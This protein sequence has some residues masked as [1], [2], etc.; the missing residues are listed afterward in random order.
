[1]KLRPYT[2]AARITTLAVVTIALYCDACSRPP[3]YIR[4]AGGNETW[5][6]GEV[7]PCVNMRGAFSAGVPEEPLLTCGT[8]EEIKN[9]IDLKA[10]GLLRP[11]G[12]EQIAL[13]HKE[14]VLAVTATNSEKD[15]WS[16]L[17]TTNGLSCTGED[18][19][20]QAANGPTLEERRL[21]T[22]ARNLPD[23][24]DPS[25]KNLNKLCKDTVKSELEIAAYN[26]THP[27]NNQQAQVTDLRKEL[28]GG[29]DGPGEKPSANKAGASR[30]KAQFFRLC[31][32]GTLPP[33]TAFGKIV[34]SLLA[35]RGGR[36]FP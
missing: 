36:R 32:S 9:I 11:I 13:L 19:P 8:E 33:R 28:C 22:W 7:R 30:I 24:V 1:M 20:R 16:C 10:T 34:S 18:Q 6:Q 21:A 35:R 4:V 5:Q 31:L 26:R 12:Q 14:P 17:K 3:T 27:P 29:P 15:K 25:L 23:S 2:S